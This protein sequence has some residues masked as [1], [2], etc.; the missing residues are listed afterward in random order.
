[1]D[2]D[3]EF[4]PAELLELS[5]EC[6][7]ETCEDKTSRIEIRLGRFFRTVLPW[8]CHAEKCVYFCVCKICKELE[9]DV[10]YFGSTDSTLRENF[11]HKR[12]EI[13]L[14]Q[15]ES[16]SMLHHHFWDKHPQVPLKNNIEIGVL[17]DAIEETPNRKVIEHRMVRKMKKE[18]RKRKKLGKKCKC[19]VLNQKHN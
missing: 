11:N 18:I 9:L 12:S 10:F 7:H 19:V 4:D 1:M 3:W 14:Y 2:N 5:D 13:K 17:T 6:C 16:A 8:D 15:N